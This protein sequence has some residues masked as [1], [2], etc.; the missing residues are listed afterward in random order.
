LGL[1]FFDDRR[2]AEIGKCRIDVGDEM[3]PGTSATATSLLLRCAA[4]MSL[5][6]VISVSDESF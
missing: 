4:T 1:G 2:L 3:R 6:S 5:V